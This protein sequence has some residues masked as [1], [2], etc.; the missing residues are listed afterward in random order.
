MTDYD[1]HISMAKLFLSL[2]DFHTKYYMPAPYACYG[3]AYPLTLSL[4][5]S[6]DLVNNPIVFVK[7]FSDYKDVMKLTSSAGIGQVQIGDI[8]VSINGMSIAQL[9]TAYASVTGGANEFGGQRAL[10][11]NLLG[12]TSGK[13]YPLTTDT[14]ITYELKRSYTDS[15]S[16]TLVVPL[17][18][19]LCM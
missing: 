18:K 11:N 3:I 16:Y 17:S 8:V 1:F 19:F 15:Q 13:K 4:A 10:L 5:H 2:R 14:Q 9:Y 12:Y 7:S 6:D